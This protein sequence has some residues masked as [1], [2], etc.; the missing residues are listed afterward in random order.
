[1][2]LSTCI[3]VANGDIFEIIYSVLK[4]I[5]TDPNYLKCLATTIRD[6]ILICPSNLRIPLQP[7]LSKSPKELCLG[8]STWV[9]LAMSPQFIKDE[10]SNQPINVKTLYELSET[11]NFEILEI[12]PLRLFLDTIK[13]EKQKH[14]TRATVPFITRRNI[15]LKQRR[16]SQ[17]RSEPKINNMNF[18]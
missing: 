13:E 3:D 15:T 11:S 5:R 18:D 6:T 10:I 14:I 2:L 8:F 17:V 7:L 1:M 16:Q 12:P 9:F 4:F